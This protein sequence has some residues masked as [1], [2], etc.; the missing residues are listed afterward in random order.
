[1]SR[2]TCSR[3]ET[4]AAEELGFT[5]GT[6][7]YSSPFD[8]LITG[9][10]PADKLQSDLLRTN[11]LQTLHF[12]YKGNDRGIRI[13]DGPGLGIRKQHISIASLIRVA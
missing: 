4:L 5:M 12:S 11:H 13:V 1:M 2:S 7:S 6:I 10:V 8:T 3:F 9:P